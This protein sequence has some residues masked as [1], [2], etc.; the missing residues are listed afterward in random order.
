LN[1]ITKY[2]VDGNLIKEG[3]KCDF[4]LL[5]CEKRKAY[6]IEL[7]GSNLHRA[8]DQI[9]QTIDLLQSSIKDDFAI[10]ARIVLTR[11]NT[12]N[13]EDLKYKNL[14]KKVENLNGDLKKGSIQL[15]E[16]NN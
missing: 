3:K 2:R 9:N 6:F 7:K 4:L 10:Y 16:I 13:L 14:N 1:F 5:N 11:V 12:I 15:R 8:I